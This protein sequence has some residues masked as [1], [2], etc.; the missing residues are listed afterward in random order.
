M[1]GGAGCEWYF[2]YKYAHNDLG[3][4]DYRSRDRMWD[5]TRFA[6][7]FFQRH[8]P[9]DEMS[10]ADDLVSTPGVFCLARPGHVYA[11]YIPSGGEASLWL[12]DARYGLRWYDPRHGGD[13][14]AGGEAA[15]TGG[16]YRTIR[17]PPAD[18]S[19]DWVALIRLEG[20]APKQIAE[21]PDEE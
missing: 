20:D 19:R 11:L 17:R 6:V 1:A 13:L 7:E 16:G 3:L 12:P 5:Q 15:V 4:E 14:Q 9:F 18:P 2:G 21:P 10:S 8:L